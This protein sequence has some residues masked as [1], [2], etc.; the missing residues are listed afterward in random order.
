MVVH[1]R[2]HGCSWL[3]TF[4]NGLFSDVH[5]VFTNVHA[6]PRL[7]AGMSMGIHGLST[8][9]SG[10][11]RVSMVV[12]GSQRAVDECPLTRCTG[13]PGHIHGLTLDVLRLA[14]N[15]HGLYTSVRGCRHG[16]TWAHPRVSTVVHEQSTNECPR[17]S[18][19]IHGGF[20]WLLTVVNGPA[21]E[22][23]QLS[24]GVDSCRRSLS[25]EYPRVSSAE[26]PL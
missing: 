18:D 11:L 4:M 7:Y 22:V 3:P 9:S 8:I 23:Q 19:G 2:V 17:M 6:C 13:V 21:T 26:G 24:A 20:P 25:T 15:V 5:D 10:C 12:H 1:G 14:V 16:C